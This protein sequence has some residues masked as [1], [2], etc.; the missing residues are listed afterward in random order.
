MYYRLLQLNTKGSYKFIHLRLI[1]LEDCCDFDV[2]DPLRHLNF[3]DV[4]EC[5]S[6]RHEIRNLNNRKPGPIATGLQVCQGAKTV[7]LRTIA[8][9]N[10]HGSKCVEGSTEINKTA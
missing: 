9:F 1:N 2:G 3:D 6:N 8:P 4:L 10:L 7:A 5:E